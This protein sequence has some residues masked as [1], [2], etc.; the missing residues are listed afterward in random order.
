MTNSMLLGEMKELQEAL[1]KNKD[2]VLDTFS[3][4]TTQQ[5]FN[6]A[7][8]L[9]E[10]WKAPESEKGL[11]E[12]LDLYGFGLIDLGEGS[13]IIVNFSDIF[14]DTMVILDRKKGTLAQDYPM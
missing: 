11:I 9:V 14:E 7:F 4:M 1:Y 13:K 2:K 3:G 10:V 8:E 6:E 12:L 5:M